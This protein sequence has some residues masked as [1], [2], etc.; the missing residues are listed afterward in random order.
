MTA[1]LEIIP[2]TDDYRLYAENDLEKYRAQSFFEKEP[3]T[4]AWIQTLVEPEDVFWDI[5]ANIGLYAIYTGLRHPEAT[6]YAFEPFRRNYVRLCQNIALNETTNVHPFHLAIDNAEAL[7]SLFIHDTRCGGSGSQVGH[8]TDERGERFA[9]T[10]VEQVLSIDVDTLARQFGFAAPNHLKID[11][12]G[13]EPR[14]IDGMQQT[15]R[16]PELKSILVEINNSAGSA[17]PVCQSIEA[18]GFHQDHPLNHAEKHSR[19]RRR[20]KP[21]NVAENVIFT[22]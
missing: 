4:V 5:G 1:N 9:P 13:N 7:A 14:I 21:G 20:D 15:L 19:N 11:V 10:S 12:D 3:E 16:H 2:V 8:D 6:V 22:R 17:D 18:A